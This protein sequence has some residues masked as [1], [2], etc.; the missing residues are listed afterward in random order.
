MAE[1]I[2]SYRRDCRTGLVKNSVTPTSLA[3][4]WP[5]PDEVS[6]TMRSER[7]AGDSVIRRASSTPSMR[8][9][10]KSSTAMS[11]GSPLSAARVSA[12]SASWPSGHDVTRIPHEP[13]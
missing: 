10:L 13:R 3:A 12:S 2:A 11:N 9:M 8:G 5:V 7:S 6:I 1:A 4:A